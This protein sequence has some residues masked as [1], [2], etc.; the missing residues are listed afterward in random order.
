MSLLKSLYASAASL[1]IVENALAA[2]AADVFNKNNYAG[3]LKF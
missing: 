2:D 3:G 1:L